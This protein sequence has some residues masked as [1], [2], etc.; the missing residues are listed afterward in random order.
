MDSRVHVHNCTCLP[1]FLGRIIIVSPV[2]TMKVLATVSEHTMV[3]AFLRAEIESPRWQAEILGPLA[4]DGRSRSVV[5]N[6]NLEDNAENA[7]RAKLLA[8]RGYR[9]RGI[10]SGFPNPV[11]W[12]SVS[13]T[14][15]DLAGVRV[16]NSKPW[17][18]FSGGTR[19]AGDAS[20]NLRTGKITH[21]VSNDIL[22]TVDHLK[23]GHRLP[24]IILVGEERDKTFVIF[25]GHVRTMAILASDTMSEVNG[26]IGIAPDMHNWMFY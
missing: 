3:E 1:I 9:D 21:E 18:F 25:E 12:Y 17:P 24:E 15:A 20:R 22:E 4:R 19:L 10:F 7:Y 5:D 16:I 26:I 6:A 14:C 8:Y 11:Q 13:L 2:N 23:R